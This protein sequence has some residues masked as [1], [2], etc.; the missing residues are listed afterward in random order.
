MA[1]TATPNEVWVLQALL[2][3]ETLPLALRL[4]P[5][6]PSLYDDAV[7]VSTSAGPVPVKQTAEYGRLVA[8]DAIDAAGGVDDT[9][10]DWMTV[11]GRAER[12]VV[13]AI[14]R[15]DPQTAQ[16]ESP[17][18]QERVMV[19]CRHRQWMAMA[20]RDGEE[21]IIDAVGESSDPGQQLELI[22]N[23]LLPAFGH[24]EAADIEGVNLPADLMYSTLN[25][26]AP[27]G[28]DALTQALGR[29]GIQ[30][31]L[32]H[33]LSAVANFGQSAMAVVSLVDSGI[34]QHHHPRVL[35]VADTEFGRVSI[36]TSTSPD[37]REWMTIWPTTMAGLRDDL[38]TLLDEPV[39]A[40]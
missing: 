13:L 27:H 19:V 37:G 9:V 1:L 5:F 4:Q 33:V 28:R 36:T 14:R 32:T 11:L 6:I 2:G 38:I 31:P 39:A 24:A 26:A 3:V 21:V 22:C 18:V 29:L 40:A 7:I 34:S 10:R 20:A 8:V 12:Q 23:A 16:T 30:S 15:P 35:T 25:N 17:T